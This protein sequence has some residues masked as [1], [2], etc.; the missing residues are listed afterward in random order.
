M[1]HTK[2]LVMHRHASTPSPLD[3]P[4]PCAAADALAVVDADAAL[5]LMGNN[6]ALYLEIAHSFML[7]ISQLTQR[8]DALLQRGDL[9]AAR[10]T[11][12]SCKGLSLT[13]GARQLSEVCRQCEALLKSL[14]PSDQRPD[15]PTLNALLATLE[16]AA[17]VAC[18]ALAAVIAKLK[19][20]ACTR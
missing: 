18:Q 3:R 12:H 2:A 8:L 20:A 15:V 16:Q 9:G 7:D 19:L 1:V 14:P 17:Q 13:V 11:L 5:E 4:L 10:R 6:T